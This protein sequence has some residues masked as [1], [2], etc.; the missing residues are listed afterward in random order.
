MGAT[1]CALRGKKWG[2]GGQHLV[3]NVFGLR[4]LFDPSVECG[5]GFAVAPSDSFGR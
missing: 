4:D 3:P 1:I 2:R 5:A